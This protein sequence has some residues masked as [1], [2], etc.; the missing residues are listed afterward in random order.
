MR[1]W[2]SPS[3]AAGTSTYTPPSVRARYRASNSMPT[4]PEAPVKNTA[5][6]VRSKVLSDLDD[7]RKHDER[8]GVNTKH[9]RP[10]PSTSRRQHVER[11]R[12]ARRDISESPHKLHRPW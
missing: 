7:V 12:G 10:R 4:N 1:V 11:L 5:S 3:P 2:A 8:V 6:V 9:G